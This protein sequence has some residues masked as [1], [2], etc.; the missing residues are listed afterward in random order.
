MGLESHRVPGQAVACAAARAMPHVK[1]SLQ[2]SALGL[3]VS[4]GSRR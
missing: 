4:V 1:R 2:N 3:R